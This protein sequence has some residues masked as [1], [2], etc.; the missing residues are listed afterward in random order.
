L[1]PSFVVL[2]NSIS[3]KTYLINSLTKYLRTK[4][5][6]NYFDQLASVFWRSEYYLYHAYAFYQH[7]IIFKKF[8]KASPEEI[9]QKTDYFVLSVLSIPP[10]GL[11]NDQSEEN[12][13]RLCKIVSSAGSVSTRAELIATI[14]T[15]NLL[16]LVSPTVRD[17]FILMEEKFSLLNFGGP[18][19]SL[20]KKMEESPAY[21]KFINQIKTNFAYKAIENAS[22]VYKTMKTSTLKRFLFFLNSDEIERILLNTHIHEHI[23]VR[24]N[25]EKKVLIFNQMNTK[26]DFS[27]ASLHIVNFAYGVK[28]VVSSLSESAQENARLGKNDRN[29]F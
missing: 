15:S 6:S 27:E 21:N 23:R 10:F 2:K 12:R 7:F 26:A 3:Y 29:Y 25:Q 5:L 22:N 4:L 16:D 18:A 9:S 1:P 13:R 28:E 24:I 8:S 19:E 20:L 14:Q 17:L 11:E